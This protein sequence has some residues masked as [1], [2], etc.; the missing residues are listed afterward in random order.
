MKNF[1]IRRA[2]TGFTLIELLVTVA[3]AGILMLLA[4]PSLTE[5]RRNAELT[6]IANKVVGS[7][8]AAR[9]EALKRGMDALM[10]PIDNGSSWDAGWVSFVD[11]ARSRTYD[12][13]VEG[14]VATQGPI[15]AGITV[16]G[17]GNATGTAPYIMFNA[18]GYAANKTAGAVNNLRL[19]IQ[20]ND[21]TGAE[22]LAQTRIVRVSVTG[23]VTVCRP[24]SATDT[25]CNPN[26]ASTSF[27]N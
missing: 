14:T 3:I 22:Q 20:R 16:T 15:P 13:T 12:A 19:R 18:S 10:V 5:F 24:V 8:N 25:N 1:Q 6:S 23:R 21:V 26:L 2:L 4:V 17:N 27:E 7:I 9:G 11:K